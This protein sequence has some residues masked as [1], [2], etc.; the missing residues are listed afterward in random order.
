[1]ELRTITHRKLLPSW[2]KPSPWRLWNF[3][4][5]CYTVFGISGKFSSHLPSP[6]AVH[7]HYTEESRKQ[8]SSKPENNLREAQIHITL[9][10]LETGLRISFNFQH[11]QRN[12]NWN[13]RNERLILEDTHR[14]EKKAEDIFQVLLLRDLHFDKAL[15]IFLVMNADHTENN[16]HGWLS[17][18]PCIP[19]PLPRPKNYNTPA[20]GH[21]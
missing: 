19:L 18:L 16:L 10:K 8:S 7:R 12:R 21:A 20:P 5:V 2:A 11:A 15:K 14:G 3:Y 9:W 13:R 6:F 1:M 4:N 17:Q